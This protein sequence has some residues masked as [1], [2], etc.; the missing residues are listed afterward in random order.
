MINLPCCPD[1]SGFTYITDIKTLTFVSD[2]GLLLHGERFCITGGVKCVRNIHM[3]TSGR[4]AR[5]FWRQIHWN[6]VKRIY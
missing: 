6:T 5:H 4:T 1:H 3:G 2:S